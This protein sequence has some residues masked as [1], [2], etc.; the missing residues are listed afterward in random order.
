MGPPAPNVVEAI[1]TEHEH[2]LTALCTNNATSHISCRE[3]IVMEVFSSTSARARN[4]GQ[5][6]GRAR[7]KSECELDCYG[8]TYKLYSELRAARTF[9]MKDTDGRGESPRKCMRAAGGEM[10]TDGGCSQAGEGYL[11]KYT[12]RA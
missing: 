8:Y 12:S 10:C 11:V 6:P 7:R 3:T 1:P 2:V 4:R 9:R 5:P